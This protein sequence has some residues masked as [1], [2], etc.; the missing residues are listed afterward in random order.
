MDRCLDISQRSLGSSCPRGYLDVTDTNAD[1]RITPIEMN[2]GGDYRCEI[3]YLDVSTYCPVVHITKLRTIAPPTFVN[4]ELTSTPGEE[5]SDDVVG[6]FRAGEQVSFTCKSGGGQPAPQ[7]TWSFAGNQLEDEAVNE[8][9]K[10]AETIEE[11]V[12]SSTLSILLEREHTG[13]Y[14]HCESENEASDEPL[15]G[16]V[17]IDVNVAVS[18]VEIEEDGLTGVENEEIQ[19]TCVASGGRPEPSITWNLSNISSEFSTKEE[20]NILEDETFEKISVLSFNPSADDNGERVTCHAVNDVMEE[21][22]QKEAVLEIL[23]S[24]RVSVHEENMMVTIGHEAVLTCIVDA[25]PQNLSDVNWFLDDVQLN[26]AEDD[27]YEVDV[28]KASLTISPVIQEDAGE[29]RC[30]AVNKVGQGRSENSLHLNVLYP[31]TVELRMEPGSV[32]E[33]DSVENI[34]LHCDLLDGNPQDLLEIEWFYNGKPLLKN[35]DCSEEN[36][37]EDSTIDAD[38]ILSEELMMEN[39][40][41]EEEFCDSDIEFYEDD[42][43]VAVLSGVKR[44]RQ[45]NYSCAGTNIAGRSSESESVRLVILYAPSNASILIDEDYPIKGGSVSFSCLVEDLGNPESAQFI[46]KQNDVI[47]D[48]SSENLTISDLAVS[49]QAEF[50]CAAVNDIGPGGFDSLSLEVY[51]P[52]TLVEGLE[53]ENIVIAN[54][55]EPS[56][57][58]QVECKPRCSISW[59]LDGQLV[60]AEEELYTIEE[61]VTDENAANNMFETVVSTFQWNTKL[62]S[63]FS[64]STLTCSTEQAIFESALSSSTHIT[65]QYPP[66]EVI[67]SQTVI[68]VEEGESVEAVVCAADASPVADFVWEFGSEVLAKQDTLQFENPIQRNQGGDYYCHASNKHGQQSASLSINVLFKPECETSYRLEGEVIILTC[69]VQANPMESLNTWWEKDNNT[70]SEEQEVELQLTNTSLGEYL[71]KVS[72][73][74]GEGEACPL[75][76]TDVIFTKSLTENDLII[77]LAVAAAVF[78]LLLIICIVVCIRCSKSKAQPEKVSANGKESDKGDIAPHPDKSFYENLPFHGLKQPPK[79]VI[80]AR[81]SQD[82]DYADADYKDLYVE[83]PMGYRKLSENKANDKKNQSNES[84]L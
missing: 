58:C 61:F 12:T 70:I 80:N 17:Q 64:N 21:P 42:V 69:S 22:L 5:I 66:E 33:E 84:G 56:F 10:I 76:I 49:T 26:M 46:W 41:A 30:S 15:R 81:L 1:L 9:I 52:P 60:T 74:V 36:E 2:D 53:E 45:G 73:D 3:T 51:V 28:D 57:S 40:V 72:N 55:S 44:H 25:N 43:S 62:D 34:T 18:S 63:S 71:C 78:A 82:M 20:I 4:L 50:S 24:P 39:A 23:Y 11:D 14:L 6:P 31:P 37:D 19:V 83:G 48:E 27:R 67:T 65:I 16:K 59:L 75:E 32:L 8:A 47:L 54:Q 38:E 77:I 79:E 13:E 35:G 29:Y 7:I 68:E